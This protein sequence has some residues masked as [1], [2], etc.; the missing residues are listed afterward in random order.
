M[1]RLDWTK[2]LVAAPGLRPTA[3]DGAVPIKPTPMAAPAAA[4]PT[5]RFPFTSS[6][7]HQLPVTMATLTYCVLSLCTRRT[8]VWL[9]MLAHQQREDRRQQHED[10]RLHQTNQ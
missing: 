1:N 10:Q 4:K 7:L 9:L 3:V 8:C 5:C 6:R 2:I